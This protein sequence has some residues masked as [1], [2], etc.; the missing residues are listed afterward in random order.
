[1]RTVSI[2]AYSP[3]AP[4]VGCSEHPLICVISASIR[5]SSRTSAAYPAF[6]SSGAN[7]CTSAN[8]AHVRGAMI[9]AAFSFIVHDPSGIMWCCSPTS[10][11]CSSCRY[12]VIACSL[13]YALNLRCVMKGV[14][15]RCAAGTSGTVYVRASSATVK[16]TRLPSAN[17]STSRSTSWSVAV[18]SSDTDTPSRISRTLIPRS[19]QRRWSAAARRASPSGQNTVSNVSPAATGTP[20]LRSASPSRCALQRIA[21]AMFAIPCGPWYIP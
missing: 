4:L 15:R 9:A 3:A 5:S 2:P 21:P 11:L 16:G 1:M 14:V 8:S 18:S 6:C 10:L 12:R 19:R 20:S 13:W 17:A 7:G